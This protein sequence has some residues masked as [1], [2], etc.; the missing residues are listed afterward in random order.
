MRSMSSRRIENL[1]SM[2][3][4]FSNG[5]TV[6]LMLDTM[7]SSPLENEPDVTLLQVPAFVN[8]QGCHIYVTTG[9]YQ[10]SFKS[11]LMNEVAMWLS[12]LGKGVR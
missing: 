10:R 12:R 5:D 9:E 4:T 8:G 2:T 7:M 3:L 1:S 11:P 6:V